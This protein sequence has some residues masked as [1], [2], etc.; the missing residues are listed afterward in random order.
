VIADVTSTSDHRAPRHRPQ[1][2]L[3]GSFSGDTTATAEAGS[4][5]AGAQHPPK[6]QQQPRYLHS[7]GAQH[8]P[9][10]QQQPRYLHSACAQNNLA[11]LHELLQDPS[12]DINKPNK[13]RRTALMGAAFFGHEEVVRLLLSRGADVNARCCEGATP[14]IYA[15]MGGRRAVVELLL[16]NGA[17][18]DVVTGTSGSGTSSGPRLTARA[19]ALQAGDKALAKLIEG[20]D[21]LSELP[22][23]IA[24]LVLQQLDVQALVA[25]SAVS[26][27]WYV[28]AN[29]P[30]VWRPLSVRHGLTSFLGGV[31][32]SLLA[33]TPSPA[34][35]QAQKRQ[36]YKMFFVERRLI[37]RNWVHGHNENVLVHTG[38][39]EPHI[40]AT[41]DQNTLVLI[42]MATGKLKT[43]E[44]TARTIRVMS[45]ARNETLR[46]C[47]C[48]AFVAAA[49]GEQG[50]VVSGH[51][52][53]EIIV[54]RV[55][56]G[57]IVQ[58]VQ[59]AH[60][61]NVSVLY[62]DAEHAT[63]VS[64][65]FD[66]LVRLW[67]YD[68]GQGK[69]VL[70]PGRS[71]QAHHV[72]I[73][74]VKLVGDTLVTA[75]GDQIVK[76]W[77]NLELVMELRGHNVT[78]SKQTYCILIFLL[79]VQKA[80]TSIDMDE[81]YIYSGGLDLRLI[82]KK[83]KK[84]KK[85]LLNKY[86]YFLFFFLSSLATGQ[87]GPA[88]QLCHARACAVGAT[89]Q[90]SACRCVHR[91]PACH[92]HHREP[93]ADDSAGR[94]VAAEQRRGTHRRRACDREVHRGAHTGRKGV[95]MGL[96]PQGGRGLVRLQRQAQ[97]H[98]ALQPLPLNSD[99]FVRNASII[100]LAL[101]NAV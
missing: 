44:V 18:R 13:H 38:T 62:V 8:P 96:F 2:Q 24:L 98:V 45:A 59:D 93:W 78:T 48:C 91:H 22:L 32:L 64:A 39:R 76:V 66:G 4:S 21:V 80:I 3:R 71:V 57:D 53:G 52:D 82:S 88:V 54:R 46:P 61:S 81:N 84:I 11:L 47:L 5:S 73:Y 77:R 35:Q 26:K 58:V 87:R 23:E 7:A 43:V 72:D 33:P 14:L 49:G 63:V 34:Q 90:G 89:N 100:S 68:K 19:I 6:Q 79:H 28:M 36:Q 37:E 85:L 95:H 29:D 15:T 60:Q 31:P 70:R 30:Q 27:R 83:K 101:G 16:A 67:H 94:D 92:Q 74:A 56:N 25:A 17:K 69:F 20:R 40:A 99:S 12:L 9:K 42:S 75:G 65:S 50:Y 86:A 97:S 1:L 41:L 51:K 55:A 10:Q